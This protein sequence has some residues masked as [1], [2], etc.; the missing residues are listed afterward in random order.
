VFLQE[1]SGYAAQPDLLVRSGTDTL[2][3]GDVK[4]KEWEGSAGASDVYQLL[5][6]AA[7]FDCAQ[8]FIVYPADHFEM[9]SLGKSATG[10]NTW[11]FTVSLRD[12]ESDLRLVASELGWTGRSRSHEAPAR[13]QP[14]GVEVAPS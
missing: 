1:P 8:A 7:A 13:S 14:V 6:H 9:R 2:A 5:V 3:I 12:L 10:A 11:F 4:Y